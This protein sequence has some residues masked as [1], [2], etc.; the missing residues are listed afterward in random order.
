MDSNLTGL[1]WN[2]AFP[3]PREF[4]WDNVLKRGELRR[5]AEAMRARRDEV[6]LHGSYG[7]HKTKQNKNK[8]YGKDKERK[9]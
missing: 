4:R 1:V 5:C 8:M 3:I 6:R 7:A 2:V 9:N